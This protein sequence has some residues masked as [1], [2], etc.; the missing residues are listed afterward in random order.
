MS[1]YNS[2]KWISTN[3]VTGSG[4]QL[5]VNQDAASRVFS[6]LRGQ[7]INF[8]CVF[9]RAR[10]GKSFLMNCLSGEQELFRVSNEKDSCTQGIDM[11]DKWIDIRDFSK[12]DDGTAVSRSNVKIGFIDAEG[13]GDRNV[14]YDAT[15]VCPILLISKCVIFNWK[16][17]LQKDH[18]LETLGIMTKAASNVSNSDGKGTSTSGPK[19]SHLHIVFRDWQAENCNERTVHDT[20]FNKEYNADSATRDRIRDEVLNSFQSVRVWLFDAPTDN[21][22]DLRTRLTIDR[23]TPEF[24]AQVRALRSV[25]SQQLSEPTYFAGQKV[26]GSSINMIVS[27]VAET[28]NSG[29]VV[30]P[31]SMFVNMM[32]LEVDKLRQNLDRALQDNF[33]TAARELQAAADAEF[34]PT[35]REAV[36]SLRYKFL[37]LFSEFRQTV[38]MKVGEV[39][40]DMRDA[41]LSNTI[42]DAEQYADH[43]LAQL[44]TAYSAV[45]SQWLLR[46]RLA[47]EQH[48]EDSFRALF[49]NPNDVFSDFALR[50]Q[51]D[52]VFNRVKYQLGVD[53]YGAS[54]ALQDAVEI[55]TKLFKTRC[56]EAEQRNTLNWESLARQEAEAEAERERQAHLQAINDEH[57]QHERPQPMVTCGAA[58]REG[59]YADVDEDDWSSYQKPSS[60]ATLSKAEQMRRAQQLFGGSSK[61]GSKSRSKASTGLSAAEQ[62]AN[63]S[64]WAAENNLVVDGERVRPFNG[65]LDG[66]SRNFHGDMLGDSQSVKDATRRAEM[67]QL[68]VTQESI[69]RLSS[70]PKAKGKK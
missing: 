22:A 25:L 23:T 43:M 13:Q 68:R 65:T 63:A 20:L 8:V 19:F 10:Q 59:A 26:T 7:D 11:S 49:T 17:D 31:H 6:Q 60:S 5:I 40:P 61:P 47:L 66:H 21:I 35:E 24:R 51:F 62:L 39:T 18:I 52:M 37:Q 38:E 14:T 27:G 54:P 53:R 67:N 50:D 58:D 33:T 29:D 3:S 2:Y 55:I 42:T 28:L 34:M 44:S 36:E 4:R 41:I 64:H 9:G 56:A 45:F 32:R 57:D 30:L 69:A 15:L 48:V 1:Q 12:I 70:L 16:G 46:T